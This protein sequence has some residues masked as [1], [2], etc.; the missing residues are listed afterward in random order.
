MSRLRLSDGA[1]HSELLRVSGDPDVTQ[2]WSLQFL[3]SNLLRLPN[4]PKGMLGLFPANAGRLLCTDEMWI[5]GC[6]KTHRDS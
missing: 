4:I 1:Q 3:E 6:W 5:C 2:S